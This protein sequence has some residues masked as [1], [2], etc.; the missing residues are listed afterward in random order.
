M[1]DDD[2][3]QD[4]QKTLALLNRGETTQGRAKLDLSRM[5]VER[6]V[7]TQ[8]TNDF[9]ERSFVLRRADSDKRY[10]LFLRKVPTAA[11]RKSVEHK[12]WRMQ[13]FC[14]AMRKQHKNLKFVLSRKNLTVTRDC[15]L[16]RLDDTNTSHAKR[17]HLG[18]LVHSRACAFIVTTYFDK[19]LLQHLEEA[20]EGGD[21]ISMQQL[22]AWLAQVV[23]VVAHVADSAFVYDAM[24]LDDFAMVPTADATI[25]LLG[26]EYPTFGYR[27]LLVPRDKVLHSQYR[28]SLKEKAVLA[29]G[30]S[31]DFVFS[32][33]MRDPMLRQ[34]K[35]RADVDRYFAVQ[36]AQRDLQK[37]RQFALL[38]TFFPDVSD[39]TLVRFA[40]PLFFPNLYAAVLQV[41][42][43]QPEVLLINRE[44]FVLLVHLSHNPRQMVHLVF[45]RWFASV[46]EH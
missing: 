17:E 25:M 6:E 28:P 46:N 2:S 4:I 37:T 39:S 19:T 16:G 44:D 8:G 32:L 41:D 30:Q 5:T 26:H 36:S 45:W 42:V 7:T 10:V 14:E 29:Q 18:A 34:L 24:D 21:K 22:M 40:L 15:P 1:D 23:F 43:Q 3:L 11:Q 31:L 9:I 20:Q 27:L 12:I 38:R 33:L 35:Q 13:N